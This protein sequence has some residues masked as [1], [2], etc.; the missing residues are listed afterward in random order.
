MTQEQEIEQLKKEIARL[1]EDLKRLDKF[2]DKLW[3]EM[4][5]IYDEVYD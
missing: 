5:H 2:V 4:R 1:E 3:V